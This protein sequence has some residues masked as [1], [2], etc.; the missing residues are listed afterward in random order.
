M[1]NWSAP[2]WLSSFVRRSHCSCHSFHRPRPLFSHFQELVSEQPERFFVAELIREKIFLMYDQEIP[3]SVQVS[4]TAVAVH[5]M[6]PWWL[7]CTT[8]GV[9]VVAVGWGGVREP[10]PIPVPSKFHCSHRLCAL[11]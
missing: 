1:S 3:Y 6:W 7:V 2:L 5:L 9:V 4:S 10:C 11:R 8:R